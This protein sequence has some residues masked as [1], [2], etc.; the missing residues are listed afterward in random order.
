MK[1]HYYD[2]TPQNTGKS[3]KIIFRTEGIDFEFASSGGVFSVK[4]ID[5][6][7]ML[8]LENVIREIKGKGTRELEI[9]DLGCGYGVIGIVLK[10]VF[11]QISL[12]MTDI[13]EKALELAKE[14]ADKNLVK[15]AN[16]FSSDALEG[17]TD[18]YDTIV[19]NPPVR[20]GKSKVF[21]F[22][23][24]SFSRLKNNGELYVVIRKKQGAPSTKTKLENSFGNCETLDKK[25][26]YRVFRCVKKVPFTVENSSDL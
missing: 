21:E 16:I 10:R 20:A 15:F 22:Y 25:A 6:G 9:L 18:T 7:S 23:D 26:G 5:F 4:G 12:N 19:T 11:P 8:L 24:K 1:S 14:N 13:N 2:K 3:N 17:I